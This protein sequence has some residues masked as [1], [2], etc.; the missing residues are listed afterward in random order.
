MAV[1]LRRGGKAS[2]SESRWCRARIR[3]RLRY[4][5][6]SATIPMDVSGRNAN[7]ERATGY[8]IARWNP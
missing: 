8:R 5:Y 4:H 1:L 6:Q 7:T 3:H 2:E